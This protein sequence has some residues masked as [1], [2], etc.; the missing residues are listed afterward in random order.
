MA[1]AHRC[2]GVAL[3]GASVAM[4]R[5]DTGTH[6]WKLLPGG[7]VDFSDPI[8]GMV[9]VVTMVV[10]E[11]EVFMRVIATFHGAGHSVA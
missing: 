8:R 10:E 5:E 2:K 1:T 9:V 7:G 11:E 3:V 6:S 4:A